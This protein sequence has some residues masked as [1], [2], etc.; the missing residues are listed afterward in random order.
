[1]KPIPDLREGVPKA[2][3][4]YQH[5][6]AVMTLVERGGLA[7]SFRMEGTTIA[8]V[9]PI[10]RAN[11]NRESRGA[12]G[13]LFA[14]TA[15][16]RKWSLVNRSLPQFGRRTG[17]RHDD[18]RRWPRAK[19]PHAV[20]GARLCDPRTGSRC[21]HPPSCPLDQPRIPHDP[22]RKTRTNHPGVRLRT[23]RAHGLS[24]DRQA[25]ARRAL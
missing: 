15:P 1:M 4:G 18:R 19:Q 25:A 3:G 7:R 24:R 8:T 17:S 22:A 9:M 20:A 10:V 5:K 16:L 11:V 12:A 2:K 21:R 23:G 13:A 14:N 6:N